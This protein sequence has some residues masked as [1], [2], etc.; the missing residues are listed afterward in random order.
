MHEFLAHQIHEEIVLL[1]R[2]EEDA[3]QLLQTARAQHVSFGF[4]YNYVDEDIARTIGRLRYMELV[5]ERLEAASQE[6]G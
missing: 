3:N 2:A 4:E 5:V 6:D 1:Q